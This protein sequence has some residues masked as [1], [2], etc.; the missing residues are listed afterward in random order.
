[1][2]ARFLTTSSPSKTTISTAANFPR[3][4]IIVDSIF[5]LWLHADKYFFVILRIVIIVYVCNCRYIS[6]LLCAA[7]LCYDKVQYYKSPYL[8]SLGFKLTNVDS[9]S[10]VIPGASI[11]MGQGGHV[12]PYLDWG[13]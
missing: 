8:T 7:F 10:P 6:C 1:M 2:S 11:P 4:L 12:P 3:A 5:G 9:I 13:T